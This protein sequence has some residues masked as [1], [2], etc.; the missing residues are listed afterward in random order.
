MNM[1]GFPTRGRRGETF[2]RRTA[3]AFVE[4][5][6]MNLPSA[7]L[8]GEISKYRG[9]TRPRGFDLRALD[10]RA[11]AQ[12]LAGSDLG[13]SSRLKL[14]ESLREALWNTTD[15]L[16]P[17]AKKIRR[18]LRKLSRLN[19]VLNAADTALDLLQIWADYQHTEF[20][21]Y[22]IPGYT[23]IADCTALPIN[24]QGDATSFCLSL[25]A[26][27]DPLGTTTSATHVHLA[28]KYAVAGTFRWDS[29]NVW[30]KD[31]GTVSS[32]PEQTKTVSTVS[33][34]ATVP[35]HKKLSLS[36]IRN[37]VPSGFVE[38]DYVPL[39]Y[40]TNRV[41]P[42]SF[43]LVQVTT[44]SGSGGVGGRTPRTTFEFRKIEP[45][46]RNF[47]EVKTQSKAMQAAGW[48]INLLT[49]T[50]DFIKAVYRALPKKYRPRGKVGA[51][52][53]MRA[54]IVNYDKLNY[55]RAAQNVLVETLIDHIVGK[56]HRKR[57]DITLKNDLSG[58]AL[59]DSQRTSGAV[60]RLSSNI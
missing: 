25:Q 31:P 16:G 24:W 5:P 39:S 59:I 56:I 7:N 8:T 32:A 29:V 51:A 9:S 57:T 33:S 21:D 20:G 45:P 18:R 35:V 14:Q 48:L 15:R 26:G 23:K 22:T 13:L 6:P 17:V 3:G 12:F 37:R 42:G 4:P 30:H 34:V 47:R 1:R 10:E 60:S 19:P 2:R 11:V 58:N 54:I 40:P 55:S 38:A 27:G 44:F 41:L 36:Q 49:E 53:Q 43:R 50:D 52:E 28:Y 46:K